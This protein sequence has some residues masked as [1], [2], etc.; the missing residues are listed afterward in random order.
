MFTLQIGKYKVINK[1]NLITQ[2][3][4]ALAC[5]QWVRRR[6]KTRKAIFYLCVVGLSPINPDV[7]SPVVDQVN[8][9]EKAE[10]K[11]LEKRAS[12]QK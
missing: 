3:N 1:T 7:P 11:E 4:R 2:H 9:T 12:T 5:F 6:T 10:K 8:G